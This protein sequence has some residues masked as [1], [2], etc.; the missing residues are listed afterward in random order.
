VKAYHE[1]NFNFENSKYIPR[2]DEYTKDQ[3]ID[4][5]VM[6][7]ARERDVVE[8]WSIERINRE[9]FKIVKKEA[10]ELEKDMTPTS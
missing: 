2:F 10:S 1:I 9:F 4:L 7:Q 8:R 3:K 5:I 6:M